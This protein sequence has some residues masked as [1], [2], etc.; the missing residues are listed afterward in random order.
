MT[1]T[2]FSPRHPTGCSAPPRRRYAAPVQRT[3]EPS[4]GEAFGSCRRLTGG[5][6]PALQFQIWSPRPSSEIPPP[7]WNIRGSPRTKSS[8]T[9]KVTRTIW[10]SLL[11]RKLF[12]LRFRKST[13]RKFRFPMALDFVTCKWWAKRGVVVPS[14]QSFDLWNPGVRAERGQAACFCEETVP[15]Q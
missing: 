7:V 5:T 2:H 9:E 4:G 12:R 10:R 15:R 13:I 1:Q 6:V 11:R 3:W 14:H 8:R